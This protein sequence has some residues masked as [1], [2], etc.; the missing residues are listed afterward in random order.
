M[1]TS[2]WCFFFNYL[3][4]ITKDVFLSL[5]FPE[6]KLYICSDPRNWMFF[7]CTWP[8]KNI[9]VGCLCI[10]LCRCFL[11]ILSTFAML[12]YQGGPASQIGFLEGNRYIPQVINWK[13]VLLYFF[14][15]TWSLNINSSFVSQSVPGHWVIPS[16]GIQNVVYFCKTRN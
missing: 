10:D 1:L 6:S 2:F 16:F 5:G 14:S 13:S 11:W 7:S 8:N 15:F 12:L 9:L 3:L 4:Y